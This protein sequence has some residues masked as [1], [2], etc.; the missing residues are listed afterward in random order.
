ML[1]GSG[2]DAS[3]AGGIRQALH[4]E[5]FPTA[6]LAICKNSTV[7][8][9]SDTLNEREPRSGVQMTGPGGH[10]GPQAHGLQCPARVPME[11]GS[12]LSSNNGLMGLNITPRLGLSKSGAGEPTW[13]KLYLGSNCISMLVLLLHA[14]LETEL[15]VSH[16]LGKGATTKPHPQPIS[17]LYRTGLGLGT[18]AFSPFLKLN[19]LRY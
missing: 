15:K 10:H 1:E 13:F 2:N 8:A 7:V 6:C 11:Q 19:H 16:M 12:T 9:L 3:L 5:G 4:G 18:W 17:T 14:L